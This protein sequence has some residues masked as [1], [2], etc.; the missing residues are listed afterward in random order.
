MTKL[1][2]TQPLTTKAFAPFG[3]VMDASGESTKMIN[4]GKCG[5]FH[6][7]A[8]LDFSDGRAGISIFKGEK[9]T[10]GGNPARSVP[11]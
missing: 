1:I 2:K 9:E 8:R 10:L 4:Q 6:D 5:R 3:D 11:T 7:Q